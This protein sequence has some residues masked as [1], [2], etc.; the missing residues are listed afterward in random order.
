MLKQRLILGPLLILALLVGAWLDALLDHSAAPDWLRSRQ[1]DGTWHS[2]V[3]VSAL[4]LALAC[5]AARELARIL[6]SKGVDAT[7]PITATSAAAGILATALASTF[8]ARAALALASSAAATVM[9]AALVHAAR[10]RQLQGAVSAAGGALLAFVYLGL[11]FG[12]LIAIADERGAW[13]VLWVLLVTKSCDIGA[14]FV[15][16]SFGKTKL[17]AWLSP[18]KTWEGLA[19]GVAL[20]AIVAVLAWMGLAQID[21][22]A[23]AFSQHRPSAGAS[24]APHRLA[25]PHVLALLAAGVL[26]ALVGHAGDLL[27]SMFK[28]DA[29]IKDAGSSLPGFGGLLDVIDSPILVAPV[30]YW[31]LR[32][33]LEPIASGGA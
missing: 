22:A 3:V 16:R 8:E 17:I 5:L 1:A 32:A 2:G 25:F 24:P 13:T 29:G 33:V 20:G 7:T 30:A 27:A 12:F 26:F 9:I 31:W 4:V 28:R 19:G 11:M 15:G 6:R 18:G 10:K 23:A 21:P 14:Y